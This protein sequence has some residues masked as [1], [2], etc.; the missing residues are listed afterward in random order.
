MR[1]LLRVT[2]DVLVIWGIIFVFP[3]IHSCTGE[4]YERFERAFIPICMLIGGVI[5][6]V[7]NDVFLK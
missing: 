2:G 5:L 1:E 7:I 6:L 3:L 4:L